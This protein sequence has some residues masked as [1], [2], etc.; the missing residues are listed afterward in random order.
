MAPDI[1]ISFVSILV[2]ISEIPVIL[3]FFKQVIRGEDN[4]PHPVP[5]HG[6]VL[7]QYRAGYSGEYVEVFE[8]L[9]VINKLN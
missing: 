4:L 3:F 8:H 1:L 9:T 7:I 2:S 5:A 6:Q